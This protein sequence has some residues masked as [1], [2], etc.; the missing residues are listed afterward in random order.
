MTTTL[1]DVVQLQVTWEPLAGHV[2]TC[3]LYI[4]YTSIANWK[5]YGYFQKVLKIKSR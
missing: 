2:Q 5:I 1:D 4:A 3:S